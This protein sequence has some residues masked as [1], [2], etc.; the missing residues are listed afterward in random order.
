MISRERSAP[1]PG[2]LS[3]AG[4]RRQADARRCSGQPSLAGL[5]E[6]KTLCASSSLTQAPRQQFH[7][8][9]HQKKTIVVQLILAAYLAHITLS[10]PL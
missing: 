8:L 5:S 2:Q 6:H 9:S 7:S 3:R 4:G 10:K 1:F